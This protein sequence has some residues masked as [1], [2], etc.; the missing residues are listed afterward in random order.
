M[1]CTL[2]HAIEKCSKLSLPRFFAYRQTGTTVISNFRSFH[3]DVAFCAMH[4]QFIIQIHSI[5]IFES[6]NQA[7]PITEGTG[8]LVSNI[9]DPPASRTADKIRYIFKFAFLLSSLSA[10]WHLFS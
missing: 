3:R 9:P 2:Q 5:Q 7:R 10:E 6:D 8:Y 4:G 1:A